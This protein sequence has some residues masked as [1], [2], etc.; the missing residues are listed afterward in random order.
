[1]LEGGPY[2]P[3]WRFPR[4]QQQV[5]QTLRATQL[6]ACVQPLTNLT[7]LTQLH[8]MQTE[9]N[10]LV[11]S[12]SIAAEALTNHA[13]SAE[14]T[15]RAFFFVTELLKTNFF[16]TELFDCRRTNETSIP[17]SQIGFSQGT[18]ERKGL[19]KCNLNVTC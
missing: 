5:S 8:E 12:G 16:V 10:P 3:L 18:D 6:I 4:V 9:Q 15:F 17:C 11:M 1:M 13:H 7:K 19:V 2:F 14:Q